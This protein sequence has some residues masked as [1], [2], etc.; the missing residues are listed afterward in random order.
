M[1]FRVG[2]PVTRQCLLVQQIGRV[3]H[4]VHRPDQVHVGDVLVAEVVAEA[5]VAPGCVDAAQV[6]RADL[7]GQH[8][9]GDVGQLMA[10]GL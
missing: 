9:V 10:A 2:R 5:L 8:V 1:S 6:Q 4:L 3:M 7:V